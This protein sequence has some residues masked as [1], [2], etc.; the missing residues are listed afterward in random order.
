M[1]DLFAGVAGIAVSDS[2]KTD[3]THVTPSS[4]CSSESPSVD[5]DS[6]AGAP[7][8][9]DCLSKI[10]SKPRRGAVKLF[11]DNNRMTLDLAS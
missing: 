1:K 2:R 6:S 5:T 9:T 11:D 3:P 4:S 8:D 7:G 10:K